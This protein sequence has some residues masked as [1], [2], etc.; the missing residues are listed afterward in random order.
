MA[1]LCYMDLFLMLLVSRVCVRLGLHFNDF[2]LR[3]CCS[4]TTNLTLDLTYG[5]LSWQVVRL[6][7]LF[8][9]LVVLLHG[10]VAFKSELADIF[11]YLWLRAIYCN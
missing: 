9:L 6:I 7:G 10:K 1:L 5:V 2:L 8:H 3:S 11:S 4:M